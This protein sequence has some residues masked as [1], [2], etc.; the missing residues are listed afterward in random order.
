M[1][2]QEDF[3]SLESL[4]SYNIIMNFIFLRET[5]LENWK[6]QTSLPHLCA[7]KIMEQIFLE[8]ISRHVDDREVIKD[9][10]NGFTKRKI[11]TG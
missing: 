1:S 6:L 2:V 7:C 8:D 11:M 9:S 3:G 10:Q 4:W 5:V